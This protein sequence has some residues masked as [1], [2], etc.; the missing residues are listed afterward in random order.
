MLFVRLLSTGPSYFDVYEKRVV[1]HVVGHEPSQ[2]YT[3][4]FNTLVIMTS[5]NLIN[6]RC[7]HNE[8]NIFE[9]MFKNLYFPLLWMVMMITQ[10]IVV[11]VGGIAFSTAPLTAE[12]WGVSL[13]FGVGS[14]LWYQLLRLI[15][16]KWRKEQTFVS[17]VEI[18]S[19]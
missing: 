19:S 16:M 8:V 5:F 17:N 7:I 6:S 3:L 9:G 1:G 18:R 2:I 4:I 12:M 10:V 15:P 14:L 11:E 13:F